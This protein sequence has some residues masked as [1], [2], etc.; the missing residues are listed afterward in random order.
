MRVERSNASDLLKSVF[1][2]GENIYCVA[3][4][5]SKKMRFSQK[6]MLFPVMR[7]NRQLSLEN[8]RIL[9]EN[10]QLSTEIRRVLTTKIMRIPLK[11]TVLW[12]LLN[13][14]DRT[15]QVELPPWSRLTSIA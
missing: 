10:R 1:S 3:L 5:Q 6:N 11:E 15:P 14:G 12:N 9:R 8:R 13:P 7:E 2:G 4:F